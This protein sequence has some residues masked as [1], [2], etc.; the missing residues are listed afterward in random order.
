MRLAGSRFLRREIKRFAESGFE[1]KNFPVV[2][3]DRDFGPLRIASVF[4]LRKQLTGCLDNQSEW[5][6][7]TQSV[8]FDGSWIFQ[9]VR[10]DTQLVG[11]LVLR[12][13][14]HARGGSPPRSR[15]R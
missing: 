9:G 12:F 2:C 14:L 1:D 5:A 15:R 3:N 8:Y 13:R 10:D 4:G 11:H 7:L 6:V